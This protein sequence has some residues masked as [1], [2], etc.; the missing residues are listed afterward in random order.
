MFSVVTSRKKSRLLSSRFIAASVAAHLV[1]AAAA[2][3]AKV[4]PP[5]PPAATDDTVWVPVDP[6]KPVA[7]TPPPPPPPPQVYRATSQPPAP[8]GP[9]PLLPPDKVPSTILPEAPNTQAAVV[10]PGI[11]ATGDP[12]G[13]PSTGTAPDGPP[14][15]DNSVY[16]PETVEVQPTLAN[17]PEVARLLVR[18]Y[19]R[20]LADAGVAG[21]TVVEL[22]IEADGR[23]RPGSARIV[24]STND[25]F[26]DATLRLVE[27]LRFRPAKVNDQPVPVLAQIP[28]DWQAPN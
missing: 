20:I 5:P 16:I 6:V 27:R 28:I 24:S 9:P 14:A 26:A 23:V 21:R 7:P 18:N 4:G 3:N 25:Q 19:P 8:A 1:V 15:P 17:R 10:D 2:V 12:N 11:G 22:I 13:P